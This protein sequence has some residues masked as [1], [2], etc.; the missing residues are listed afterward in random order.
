MSVQNLLIANLKRRVELVPLKSRPEL[1]VYVRAITGVEFMELGPRV[2]KAEG[3]VETTAVQLE[4]FVSDESG[5]PLLA[6]GQGAEFMG[7]IESADMRRLL[8]AG[9]KMNALN[10]EAVEDEIKN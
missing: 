5:N 10:D 7:S 8:K 6:P 3:S 4:A 2:T 9:D 1:T